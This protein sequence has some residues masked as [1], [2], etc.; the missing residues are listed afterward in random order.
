MHAN[1]PSRFAHVTSI[2]LKTGVWLHKEVGSDKREYRLASGDEMKYDRNI[3]YLEERNFKTQKWGT[4]SK[5]LEPDAVG[6]VKICK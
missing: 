3:G 1:F 4:V 6:K 5:V 2:V